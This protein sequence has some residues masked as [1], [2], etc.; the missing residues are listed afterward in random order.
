MRRLLFL[1]LLFS[2]AFAQTGTQSAILEWVDFFKILLIGVLI[3]AVVVA[4]TGYVIA[5]L[6]GAQTR[7][8]IQ[9][10]SQSLLGAAG[11]S[12]LI[13]VIFYALL[14]GFTVGV[15]PTD[16]NFFINA[17]TDL[18]EL[19]TQALFILIILLVLLSAAAYAFGQAFGAE[20]RARAV[21]WSQVLITSAIIVAFIYVV[22]QIVIA[23][24]EALLDIPLLPGAYHGI[25]AS[26][27]VFISLI[28]LITYLASKI[29]HIPEWEAYLTIELSDLITS[30]LIVV[31]VVG[32][33]I[34]SGAVASIIINNP[35][36]GS[37]PAAAMGVLSGIIGDLEEIRTDAFTV[38]A[39]AS[40]LS[41]F[42][43]RTG[44]SALNITYKLFPGIDMFVSI[45]GMLANGF[46]MLEAS[47]K[48][49]LM[50]IQIIDVIAVPIFLPAGIILRFLPP[51]RDAGAFILALA[52]G[53]G[54][55]FPLTYVINE[56]AMNEINDVTDH[57]GGGIFEYKR[58][59]AMI[60][61]ICGFDLFFATVPFAA[62]TTAAG[63]FSSTLA[64]GLGSAL[65][66]LLSEWALLL[67]KASELVV[68]LD[69]MTVISLKGFFAPS[70][71]MVFTVAFINGLTKFIL[72]K[73]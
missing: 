18:V 48:A 67:Y 26:T 38:Q 63:W 47:L 32:L 46:I 30:L 6:F 36:A 34:A 15:V 17:L 70:I 53:F 54:I 45:M 65:Q 64:T 31:L 1:L 49:Q 42:H 57:G 20:K 28:V 41:T 40:V 10:W 21:F 11:V 62:I 22:I 59:K 27:I 69:A 4:A 58:P 61:S 73:G 37:P 50:L 5:Q 19:T 2:L 7:A 43:K 24:G 3:F 14:P 55:I 12:L 68:I 23:S 16:P 35:E 51:T 56:R 52:I 29:L 33:Y 9:V 25:L 71:S 60:A 66:I 8:A 13:L 72:M 44:E 39:C